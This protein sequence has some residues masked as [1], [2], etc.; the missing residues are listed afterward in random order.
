MRHEQAAF[1]LAHPQ[2]EVEYCLYDENGEEVR[3]CMKLEDLVRIECEGSVEKYAKLVVDGENGKPH[4][5]RCV[6]LAINSK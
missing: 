6:D 1:M 2:I 3:L 5:A 4:Q